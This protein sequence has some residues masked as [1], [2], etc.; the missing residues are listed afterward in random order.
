VAEF[1]N[2]QVVP[3]GVGTWG[4]ASALVHPASAVIGREHPK[5]CGGI[6]TSGQ[7]EVEQER[8]GRPRPEG[9]PY[10]FHDLTN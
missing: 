1:P 2:A 7:Q 8:P 9:A 4:P 3:D 5:P 10:G 6:T